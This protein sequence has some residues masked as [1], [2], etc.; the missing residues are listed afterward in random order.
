M[1]SWKRVS[2]IMSWKNSFWLQIETLSTVNSMRRS[3]SVLIKDMLWLSESE[4]ILL[5]RY[6]TAHLKKEA[7]ILDD[8]EGTVSS[9]LRWTIFSVNVFFWCIGIFFIFL[10]IWAFVQKTQKLSEY[11][12]FWT[13]KLSLIFCESLFSNTCIFNK[14]EYWVPTFGRRLYLLPKFTVS[15][16]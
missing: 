3:D 9:A 13:E 16:K 5:V 7:Q 14:F 6:R 12:L 4:E 15:I 1:L 10:G 2:H 8:I 11:S